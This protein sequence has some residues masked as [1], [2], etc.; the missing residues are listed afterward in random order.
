MTRVWLVRHGESLLNAARRMQGWA[1]APLTPDGRAQGAARRQGFAAEGVVFDAA[2]S[3]DGLRH[4]ETARAL[5]PASAL[6][7]DAG[8]REACFGTLEG[9]RSAT[10]ARR[11]AHHRDAADPLRAVLTELSASAGG[12]HPDAVVARALAALDRAADDGDEVLVVTS[13]VTILLLLDALGADLDHVVAGPANLSV[14]TVEGGPGRWCVTRAV[15]QA[16]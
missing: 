13:G 11:L 15:D 3:A 14:S 16:M 10:L 12:E 9:A 8:W 5:C 2:V 4:R 1:D 6:R 7:E